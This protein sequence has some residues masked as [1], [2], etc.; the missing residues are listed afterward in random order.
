MRFARFLSLVMLA[1]CSSSFA[2]VRG[3]RAAQ[4]PE[5]WPFMKEA[6]E[7]ARDRLR[8]AELL[9]V[10]LRKIQTD[11]GCSPYS[12]SFLFYRPG[13]EPDSIM[14]VVSTRQKGP[15]CAWTWLEEH[16]V[17]DEELF[18]FGTMPESIDG[19]PAT[20]ALAAAERAVGAP[21]DFD[22]HFLF[23]LSYRPI[24]LG[25]DSEERP[26]VLVWYIAGR[27]GGQNRSVAVTMEGK[28]FVEN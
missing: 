7:R 9:W 8:D 11:E 17:R 2:E 27:F 3:K 25:P 16:E 13:D 23:S 1:V 15:T 14:P 24:E 26:T 18:V 22:E 5:P 28:A 12:W 19:L 4:L 21:F 10:D 6:F 20:E